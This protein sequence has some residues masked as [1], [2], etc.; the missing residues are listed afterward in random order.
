MA[1]C[2]SGMGGVDGAA[3]GRRMVCMRERDA[4]GRRPLV[5]GTQLLVVAVSRLPQ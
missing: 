2:A 5:R 1:G 4:H 3:S